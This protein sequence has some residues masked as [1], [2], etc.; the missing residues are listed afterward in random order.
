MID[1]TGL[2]TQILHWL[3]KTLWRFDIAVEAG[4]IAATFLIS[5]IIYRIL[6]PQAVKLL[7]QLSV[8]I[9]FRLVLSN[10]IS[11][12]YPLCALAILA[13]GTALISADPLGISPYISK[14]AI[15]LLVAW[16]ALRVSLQFVENAF[17]R[18]VFLITIWILAAL[19]IF[20]I[21]DETASSLN[22]LGIDLGG[23][24][25]SALAVIKG[26]FALFIFLYIAQITAGFADRKIHNIT[27]LSLASRVLLSKITRVMLIVVA[28]LIGITSA[29]INL[30]LFAVFGGAVGLG[31][32]FG[33]Q[34]GVSN[35]FSGMLLLLDQSI[36]PGDVLE[37]PQ[38][39]TF[40]WVNTMGARYTEIVTRDH[41]SY[42]IPNEDLITQQVV[43]WSHGDSFVRIH[44]AFGVHYD[45]NPHE[46][47]KIAIEA[48][49]TAERVV[50][51]REPVCW[52]T[53]FGESSIDFDLRFWIKD[54]E[55]GV[56]NVRGQVFLALWDAFK[57][58]NIQIPYPHR[59]V[60]LHNAP[61]Q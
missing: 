44:L 50:S 16:V 32:G 60:Y 51:E 47:M 56:S 3:T 26:A 11:L 36:K 61:P 34:K 24:R 6:K 43:N 35:L 9:R 59:D 38:H 31:I 37:L 39:G 40:G 54:A 52:I 22:D 30:S 15:K 19:S 42:L 25:L 29:G 4:L 7:G 46:V 12:I 48:A 20:G 18:N 53:A 23:F 58:N 28:L 5:L 27:S 17:I 45:S 2:Y 49:K 21:L 57:A 55:N 41:K 13:I 10:L 1:F 33:L 8:P 14:I